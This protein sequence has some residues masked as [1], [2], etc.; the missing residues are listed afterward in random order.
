LS[1]L[2]ATSSTQALKGSGRSSSS[3]SSTAGSLISRG[4]R[5]LGPGVAGVHRR[6]CPHHLEEFLGGVPGL[7]PVADVTLLGQPREIHD[8]D[9]LGNPEEILGHLLG[10]GGSLLVVVREDHYLLGAPVVLGE[11]ALPRLGP[12]RRGGGDA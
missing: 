9:C 5:F 12:A 3:N 2:L 4:G 7:Q 10:I 6:R 8:F 1:I 11:L